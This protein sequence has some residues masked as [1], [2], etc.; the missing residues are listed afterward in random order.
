MNSMLNQLMLLLTI[1]AVCEDASAVD[2]AAATEPS[3]SQVDFQN[4]LIPVFTKNGCN[5]GACHGAAIGRGGFQLSLYGGDP[6]SDYQSIVQQ[7]AGRRINLAKPDQSLI[8][9]KPAEFIAHGGGTIFDVESNSAQ[10]LINWVK[11]GAHWKSSRQLESVCVSPQKH[12][13]DAIGKSV[14]FSA[15]ARYSDGTTRDVTEW[16]IFTAEDPSAVKVDVE[17]SS[18]TI[19]RRGRHIVVARFL[20][21]VVPIELLTPLTDAKL[22]LADQQQANFID[23]EILVTLETLGL[24]PSEV[25][26]DTT[27][28]RRIS[29][30]LTGRL[31]SVQQAQK[32]ADDDGTRPPGQRLLLV[33]ELLASDEF[34]QYWTLQW[35]KLLRIRAQAGDATAANTYHKWLAK[36]VASNTPY[37]EL[38][39]ALIRSEGDSAVLGPP[40][41]YRTVKDAREQTEFFSELFMGSRLRCANCHNHPLDRWTQDDYHGLAAIF[42][43]IEPGRIVRSRPSGQVIHPRTQEPAALRIPGDGFLAADAKDAR[44]A[45]SDW[46]TAE[47]NP[48]FAKAI[49]NRLWKHMMG[50]GFVEPADDFRA[51]NPATHPVLL[52]KLADDFV[53]NDYDLRHTLRTIATSTSYA[54]SANATAANKDDDRFY[55]HAARRHLEPEVLADAISDV[56]EVFEKYGNQAEGTRAVALVDPKTPSQTLDVLGRCGREESCE[57]SAG[58]VGGLRQQLHLLNGGLLNSRISAVGSRLQRLVDGGTEPMAIVTE[59]YLAALGRQPSKLE[60]Q[61]WKQKLNQDFTAEQRQAFLEDFV[62]GQLTCNEFVTNH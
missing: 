16:T 15:V 55:S 62:W 21:E 29:L 26:N 5:T 43:K 33:D 36:Q 61:H 18:A 7:L 27:F 59:F 6:K 57:S 46:L 8:V 19:L 9:L 22:N 51:T 24:P 17:S 20:N 44:I 32:F 52:T 31:P 12:V 50:R 48:Y 11:Q 58:S 40:N 25:I 13:A 39:R 47:Q 14:R 28:L 1:F 42:A 37:D 34:N 2:G 53:A 56:L 3:A 35:A 10:L 38:A 23:K 30:D 54:R 49:V 41:F 4:D 45:L 60:S